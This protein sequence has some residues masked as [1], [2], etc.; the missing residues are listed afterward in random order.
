MISHNSAIWAE[1]IWAFILFHGAGSSKMAFHSQVSCLHWGG[2]KSWVFLG[3]SVSTELTSRL[4][5]LFHMVAQ[6]SKYK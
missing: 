6:A 4:D 1:L 5:R 3:I 2:W